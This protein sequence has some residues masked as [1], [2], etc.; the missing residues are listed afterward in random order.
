MA[1]TLLDQRQSGKHA[2]AG[3]RPAPALH[4]CAS[5]RAVHPAK[6]PSQ[7]KAP[8]TQATVA[9]GG[10]CFSTPAHFVRRCPPRCPCLQASS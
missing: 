7:L 1:Q 10:A 2:M 4:L 6:Q 9:I 8:R 5:M 3:T